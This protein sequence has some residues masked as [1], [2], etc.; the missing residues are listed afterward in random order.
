MA[1][2][3]DPTKEVVRL[4][5]QLERLMARRR[6]A[7]HKVLELEAQIRETRKFLQELTRPFAPAPVLVVPCHCGND[8]AGHEFRDPVS[9]VS[10]REA[11]S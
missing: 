9:C 2:V 5:R 3:P 10:G 11:S 4:A 1:A 8:G 6:V 7:A